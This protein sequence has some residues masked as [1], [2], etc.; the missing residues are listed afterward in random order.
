[1]GCDGDARGGVPLTRPRASCTFSKSYF[2]PLFDAR[3][4][5]VA[6]VG[7]AGSRTRFTDDIEDFNR[8][9]RQASEEISTKLGHRA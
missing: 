9:V 7:I 2:S 5:C 6:A 3:D 1:M 8:H 4:E